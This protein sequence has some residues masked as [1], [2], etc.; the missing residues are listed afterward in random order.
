MK[1]IINIK[2]FNEV[3]NRG[4]LTAVFF[5]WNSFLH[6]CCVNVVSAYIVVGMVNVAEQRI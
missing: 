4:T 6:H 3:K 2:D 1:L 5:W